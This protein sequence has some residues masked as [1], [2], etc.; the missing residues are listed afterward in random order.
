MHGWIPSVGVCL[1]NAEFERERKSE[2]GRKKKSPSFTE[3]TKEGTFE[4]EADWSSVDAS[5]IRNLIVSINA[6]GG[7][8]RFGRTRDGGA[9]SMG[10][11]INGEHTNRYVAITEDINVKLLAITAEI[12]AFAASLEG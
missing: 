12:D 6:I 2:M 11:H 10:L 5:A 7:A 1:T 8:I 4:H 3:F 9:Y